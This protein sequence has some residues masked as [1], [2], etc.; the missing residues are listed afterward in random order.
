M[1]DLSSLAV[2]HRLS[3]PPQLRHAW[4]SSAAY[5]ACSRSP[6]AARTPPRS[7]PSRPSPIVCE[8]K[9]L[10]CKCSAS[11]PA[12]S[13]PTSPP[14]PFATLETPTARWMQ[15]QRTVW[16]RR[17][18]PR[19]CCVRWRRAKAT[20]RWRRCRTARRSSCEPCGRASA[21]RLWQ[22]GRPA[23]NLIECRSPSNAQ[24]LHWLIEGWF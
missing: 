10:R 17:R 11:R 24:V 6:I 19:R 23:A 1:R 5:K 16:V 20:W 15:P 18:R 3:F 21:R 9:N 2:K 7:T 22:G 14:A 8:R 12:T 4:S 13:A